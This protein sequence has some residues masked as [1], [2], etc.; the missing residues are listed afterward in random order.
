MSPEPIPYEPPSPLPTVFITGASSG[1]GRAF[2]KHFTQQASTS[3]QFRVLGIDRQPWTDEAGNQ[4]DIYRPN[5]ED[6]SS[7]CV[8]LDLTSPIDTQ[9]Q[10]VSRW[11][12]EETPIHLVVH[13]AGIRGLVPHVTIEKYSDVA[14]AETMDSM[15]AATMMRTY[16]I[17]VVGTF[18]VLTA[19]R[20]NL[21][22]A[23]DQNLDPKVIVLSS[24][25]GSIAA[26]DKGGGYAYR[27]S[28][29]A[30]NAVMTS[31][32]IDVPRVFF[33][34]VHPGRVETGLV[35]IK[36]D[37]AISPQESL[38]DLLPLIDR[39]GKSSASFKSGCFV[40]RFGEVIQW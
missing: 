35:C 9:R 34:M 1:L 2:F 37:G 8:R 38:E 26:N 3:G 19:L 14:G 36:E 33:A 13:S 39:F 15:D 25:M 27:A 5:P 16:E 10:F 23:A 40:D 17:N 7:L 30:L 29:A 18:N 22:L 6:S 11:V 20:P 4:H 28:K 32:S 12:G 21:Q 31:M 24:R